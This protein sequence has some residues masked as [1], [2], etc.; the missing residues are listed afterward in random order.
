MIAPDFPSGGSLG[1]KSVSHLAGAFAVVP[2]GLLVVLYTLVFFPGA[3][4]RIFELTARRVSPTIEAR[5]GEMLRRFSAGLSVLRTPGH[6]IAVFWWT[7]LHWLLQPL[8]FWLGFKALGINVPVSATLF[9]QGV[10]VI[11]VALPSAPGF[12]GVFEG[13]AALALGVYGITQ[14][15]ALAWAVVFHV[16]AFIPIT[17]IGA[18]YFL[19][20][21]LH[22][23]D[24]GSAASGGS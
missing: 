11:G 9:V 21:G 20:L 24:I 23:G 3:L 14:A 1:G 5:G 17:L 2:L 16:A 18:Y 12:V 10:I 8:A 6:F 13:F 7:L 15:Q 19:R 22:L 4:I